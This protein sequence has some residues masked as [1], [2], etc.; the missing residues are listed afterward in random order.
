MSRRIIEERLIK[1]GI[2]NEQFKSGLK[3]SLASL[4]NLDKTLA[5]VDGKSSFANTEKASKSLARSFTD[6]ISSAP[7]LGDAYLGVFNRLTS[8]VASATNGFG[9][10]AAGALNFISPITLGGKQAPEAIRSIDASVQQTSSKFGMLRSIASIALGNIAANAVTAGLSV[11]KNFAGK[12]LNTIVPLKAGFSQ[13]EDKVNSVNMLVAALGKSEMGHITNSLDDLQKYAETTKYSVKQM[14]N[15]LA[16]FVNAGVGLDDATTALK[17]WG[18]LAASA[19]AST[20]GF[21]RSLQ[22][23]VQQA[24]QMGMMNTQNWIS[25]ENAGMATKKF[26]DILLQTAEALGQ[27]VDLSEGFRGSLKDGWLTNEVLIKSLEQ[28]AHDETLV[29]M[30]SDFHTFGE[31][32]EAVA[33]QVTS[34][35]ARVWETLFGQAGSDELT[36]FWTKWGNAAANALSATATKANEFAKV[37]VSLGGRDKV[38]GLMDSAFGSIGGVFKTIGGAFTHVFGGNVHTVVGQKLVDIIGK[39]SEKLKLGSAELHAFQHIF[40][41]V[42]QGL[43]WIGAEVAARMK[44]VATLIPNH[45]IKNFIII[46]GMMAKALYKSIRAFEVFIGKFID[47]NKVGQFFG[48]IGDSI[49]KFWDAVHTKLGNFSEKWSNAFEGLPGAVGKIVDW[50]KK[51]WEVIKFL[52]PA[53]SHFKQ[54]FRGFFNRILNPFQNLGHALGDN[55]KKFN[56]WAFWVG[57][58]AKRFPIFGNALGKFIVGFS[59]FNKATGNM[60][61]W[62]GRMGYN[63]RTTLWNIRHTWNNETGRIKVSY[64][65][66]W[67]SLNEAMDGVLKREILT[68]KQFMDVVKWDK[69]IPPQLKNKFGE[70][71]FKMP[72]M[73]GLKAAFKSFGANPFGTLA[74]GGR[75]LSKWLDNT[76]F[77]FKWLGDI[78]RKN[79]PTLGEYADKLDKVK[80]S[81]SFLK[82]VVD[83][84]AKAFEWFDKKIKGISFGKLNFGDTGK[85]LSNAGKALSANFSEGIVPGMVKSIDGFRKWVGGLSS[86][87]SIMGG[88]SLGG[89][90]IG[91]VFSNIRSEMSK[92]KVDFSNYK[93]TLSTFKGWF[94]GFWT[95]LA[96]AASGPSFTKIGEGIKNAFHSVIDWFKS[97]FGP[98]FKSFFNGLPEGMQSGLKGAWSWI[99]QLFSDISTHIKESGLSFKNF[100]ELFGDISKGIVKALKEIWKFLKKIWEGF[101]DL[102][103]V[104]GVSA[105]EMTEADFGQRNMQKAEAGLDNLSNSVDRVHEKSRGMFASIG[106]MAKLIGETFSAILAPFSEA[107]SATVGKILTLAA[108]IIVLWNTRKKVLS[109]KDMFKDFAKGLFE[110]ANSVTGSL[111]NMFKAIGGYFKS[112]AKFENIKAFALAIAALTGSLVVLSLIPADKLKTG[113]IGLVAVLAAFEI[114]YLT[115]SMTTKKFDQN[116]VQSAKDMM[117]GML[118]IAGSILMISGSVMLL[119]NL[120]EEKLKQGLIA[121]GSILLAMTGLMAI[122]SMLQSKSKLPFGSS[123]ASKISIGI[124]TFIGLAYAIRKIAKVIKDLGILD[125]A[126]LDQGIAGIMAIMVGIMGIVYTAGNLKDVN[127]SSIFTFITMAKAIAGISKAVEELGSLPTDVLV[128]GGVAVGILLIVV[129]GI[130]LAFS[131]LDT[132]EQSF[133][134]NALAMFGGITAMLYMMRTLANSIGNMKDPN[135]IVN[136]LGAMAV[137]VAAFGVLAMTL[138][139]TNMNDPAIDGGIRNLVVIAGSVLIAATGMSLIGNVRANWGTI[140]VASTAMVGIVFAFSL[141]A[142]GAEKISYTGLVGLGASVVALVAA[143]F[144]M[145]ELTKIPVKDIWTQVGALAAVVG[146]IAIIGGILG[147][148]GGWGAVAGVLALGSALLMMGGAIG[149]AAGGIGY[150]L[151]GA[152]DLINAVTKMI[153]T[154]SRLGK[155]GGENFNKFFKE[156]S[157]SA[158]DIAT[159]VGGMAE[160]LITGLIR[161]LAGNM[162]RVI[163][164]GVELIKGIIIGLGNA[165][166]DIGNALVDIFS[167]GIDLVLGAIPRWVIKICEGLLSGIVQISQWIRNNKNLIVVS[168]MEVFAAITSVIAEGLAALLGFVTDGII[169]A[170]GW[171]PGIE[172]MMRKAK[173]A[174]YD[175]A[176]D[177]SRWQQDRINDAKQYAELTASEGVQ[178]AIRTLDKLGEAEVQSAMRFASRAKDG[179]E[180][181]KIF[182]SQLGIQ[183]ADQFINGLKNKTIDANEAG[184]LF[185]KMVEMGMS[186]AQVKQIAEKAGYDY[187]DGVLTAKPQVKTNS[188]DIKKT[189]EEGLTGNG[190]WDL[191]LLQKAFDNLNTHLGGN[192]DLTKVMA[193]LKA[194]EIPP[195]MLQALATGDFSGISQ[196]QMEKYISSIGGATDPARSSADEVRKAVEAGLSGDGQGFNVDE[197]TTAFTNL[198]NYLGTKLDATKLV[199]MIKSGEIP[200]SMI[201]EMA[202]GDFS[203]VSQKHMDEFRKPIEDEPGKT[204]SRIDD[205]KKS[206][207]T[208]TDTA[209]GEI[210]G[211]ITPKQE[212][213]NRIISDYK[214]GKRLT[215]EEMKA[216]VSTIDIHRQPAFTAGQGVAGS[217]NLGLATV[218]GTKAG[219]KAGSTFSTSVGSE[220]NKGKAN[221]AGKAVGSAASE[222]MKFDASESGASVTRSFAGGLN[223]GDVMGLIKGAAAGVMGAVR[224]FFPRSPAKTG[225]FSGDGW[226]SV[227]RSGKAIVREF[228]GGLGSTASIG[229][230]ENSMTKVQSFIQDALGDVGNYVDDNMELSPTI[231][232]VLDMTNI[233]GYRWTGMGSLTL[234]GGS[235]DYA[236][237]NPT[238][239]SISAHRSSIEDVVRGLDNMDRKLAVLTENTA[240]N[241]DLLEQGQVHPIYMDKDLVNRAL[242]PGMAEAQRSHT[243]RLN[244]LDGVLPR[245]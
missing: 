6:A 33:D 195:E 133:T 84:A 39:L 79:W 180:Y 128:K 99:K 117:L 65:Q 132:T 100:G 186:E 56:E 194:G 161:A 106:D 127:T 25:V 104:T 234:S 55:G 8:T 16:Q 220:G 140:L 82:P 66:F 150:F 26:K 211:S 119:G 68:W 163:Q 124:M 3:E 57:N 41:A 103:K 17:G 76:T 182:C 158:G 20:D 63:L 110:G 131:K 160:G 7:K 238:N 241:N 237:L 62:A 157:K 23:G 192:L 40:I 18:N 173:Q 12:I 53:I 14:H 198:E 206:A 225:P 126:K 78:V 185:A 240:I 243:D 112:K 239:Q 5:K 200:A 109:I 83:A 156:A 136:S 138:R 191:G 235:I 210:K 22:F 123:G 228:A 221:S 142:K 231:T 189:L 168:V 72:D 111:T 38:M 116:K 85:V 36:A 59:H 64:K 196:E 58:A 67:T 114:F 236:S 35:W 90:A 207:L 88:F 148:V 37:F 10:L 19:G 61:H 107:D 147:G 175:A 188:E 47:F 122:L 73:S 216:L 139:T 242:A 92:S 81:F 52:T 21:N 218:D 203:Q 70:L 223:R 229:Y 162:G 146:G 233:D 222:G 135:A 130:V 30:A 165:A 184:K 49:N 77:S 15:S 74:T 224:A 94:S 219:Q 43:K 197:V 214:E 50:F 97:V 101:K 137:V 96:H 176:E 201:T 230:V 152:G 87:K 121:A 28:L 174:M 187:A 24:L 46:V 2:D 166:L 9:K 13:F 190:N 48:K 145:Q 86:F 171:I 169:A 172:G 75:D 204:A 244:M 181:F 232:P 42:F 108:A 143:A 120:D 89:N 215:K 212:E 80:I 217:A 155:E 179:L 202:K 144:A 118:G 193:G 115:L 71:D 113:V 129:G 44:L 34:G 69:L 149:V 4:E 159:V 54:E 51:L 177:F 170:F 105:D 154:V 102:F 208:A 1:L 95:G 93:S 60:D 45:M 227:S 134:K 164:I 153:D 213:I 91:S 226:R 32:A 209:Y 27:S 11:T 125:T 205:I 31:A 178:A 199:A 29:K 245:L 167:A 98:W 151:K 183:G 141:I